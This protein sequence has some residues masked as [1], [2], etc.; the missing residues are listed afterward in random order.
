[1]PLDPQCQTLLEQLSAAGGPGLES[2]TPDEGR[3]SY[4]MLMALGGAGNESVG[5]ADRAVPGPAGDIP[6]RVYTPD[7]P[8]S[9]PLVMWFHGG[10]HV[11]GDLDTYDAVCR[12]L[13]AESGAVVVS[14]DYRLAPEHRFPAAVEDC[15]AA[16]VWAAEHAGELGADAAR[17]A[18]A[19]ESAGGNL[20]A[21]IALV[22]R[23]RGTPAIAFQALIYPATDLTR[24]HPSVEENGEGYLLTAKGMEWFNDH[25]L[26]PDGDPKHPLASPLFAEDLSGLP[27][28]LVTT[29]EFDPLRDEGEA[30]AERLRAA[31]VPVEQRRYDGLIHGFITLRMVVEA[32][33]DAL[34]EIARTIGKALTST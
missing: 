27:P 32:G 21:V 7:A 3:N 24:S 13:A 11:I 23:D 1:M 34:D 9:R 29:A 19:G 6:I 28:A 5:V 30:Y 33:G 2:L 10:G 17:L 31:G 8:A 15:Y 18:V 25:Y 22:A 20:A 12:D 26:G 16:T 4:R 14:V